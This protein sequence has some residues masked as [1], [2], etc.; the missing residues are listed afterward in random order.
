M[1]NYG[2]VCSLIAIVAGIAGPRIPDPGSE[3]IGYILEYVCMID[4]EIRN[5]KTGGCI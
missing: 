2:G 4:K 3:T 5:I 1:D